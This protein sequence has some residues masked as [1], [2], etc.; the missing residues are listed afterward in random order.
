LSAKVGDFLT[1]PSNRSKIVGLFD[2]GHLL[3]R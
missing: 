1:Q 2:V 3:A